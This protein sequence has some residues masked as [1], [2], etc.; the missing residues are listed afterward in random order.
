MAKIYS[1]E[2]MVAATLYIRAESLEEAEKIAST[3]GGQWL[4]SDPRDPSDIPVSGLRF[5]D[6]DLPPISLSPAMTLNLPH[7]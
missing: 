1:C 4:S 7:A 6:P 2:L 5:D 3:M